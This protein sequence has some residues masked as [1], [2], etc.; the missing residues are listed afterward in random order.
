MV[1]WIRTVPGA[2]WRRGPGLAALTLAAALALTGAGPA[3]AE[4]GPDSVADLAEK[5][6]GAVVNISTTQT[7]AETRQ[8]P[9]PQVPEGSP[10]QDFFDEFF[11]KNGKDGGNGGNGDGADN[12]DNG[13]DEGGGDE[14]SDPRKVQSLGSGFVIDP[15]G[16]IITNNHVI[17]DADEIV[18]NFSDGTKLKAEL[19]GHDA[20]TDLAVLRVKP[21]KPLTAV[22]FG[23]SEH[24]R[25]GDWV[26]AIGN[27]FGLGGTVTTGIISARNR[28][29]NSGPYDN[30]IQTDAAINR[31]NSG[32]PLFN[33]VGEVIGIN[34][35][36]ISPSGGSIGIGFAIPSEIAV[37][38][39]DQLREFGE[40]HRGWLGVNI[41]EVTDDLA[42]SLGIASPQ[43]AL[44]AGVTEGGPAAV[45][46]V[47]P[48]DVI[49]AFDGHA[50]KTMRELPRLVA[51]TAVGKEVSITLI[52]KGKELTLPVKLGRLDEGE[53][54]AAAKGDEPKAEPPKDQTKILG[55][56]LGALD[57][58]AREKYH[59]NAEV[60]GVLVSAV[61]PASAAAEK[62]IAAGDLIVE[63]A[64]EEVLSP[65]DVA[66]TVD[67]QKG[68]GRKSVLLLVSNAGGDLRFI[69]VK[70][71]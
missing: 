30:Y 14:G 67:K 28:D 18:A 34:T 57:D 26:M 41:Q 68:M 55:L 48:G 33:E 56:T 50:I 59:F 27:P 8:V 29:I 17:E 63:V 2:G 70:I 60:K 20:K 1:S 6:I 62:G 23:D 44:V 22:K 66:K 69:A 43:G 40:T 3:A 9:L 58:G 51:N 38:V 45:A 71:D 42:E 47:E 13:G 53:K 61:D 54:V 7:V 37:G 4:Q 24:M 5:L 39:V 16:I 19:V 12:G 15:S 25:V 49:V 10:F 46:K 35:A 65:E 31:G 11:D 64:Q 52:R 21:D 36:I 32:G